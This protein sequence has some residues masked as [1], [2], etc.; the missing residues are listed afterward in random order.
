MGERIIEDYAF[1]D[2]DGR[3][4]TRERHE[5]E[6]V[7]HAYGFFY[8]TATKAEIE[9]EI[10]GFR[11]RINTDPGLHLSVVELENLVCDDRLREIALEARSE[12]INYVL[13]GRYEFA[14]NR[15]TADGVADMLNPISYLNED[16]DQ[17]WGS[18][19]YEENGTYVF[20]QADFD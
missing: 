19:A 2:R 3:K 20:R 18:V 4:M 12:G 5:A 1:I 14:S 6:N 13:K 11:K 9:A 17:P 16:P 15:Q 8:S 7:G 10:P